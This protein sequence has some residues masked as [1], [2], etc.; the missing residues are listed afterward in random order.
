M[1]FT[2]GVFCSVLLRKKAAEEKIHAERA[3]A[4][5]G[6]KSMLKERQDISPSSRWSKVVFHVCLIEFMIT[7]T[8]LK[9]LSIWPCGYYCDAT[10]NIGLS[11][12]L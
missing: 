7:F 2:F 10:H 4:M 9:L 5:S 1:L 6:F 3:A 11:Q 12:G 8:F